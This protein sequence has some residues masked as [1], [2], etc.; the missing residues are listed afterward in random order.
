VGIAM[1]S[2][3]MERIDYNEPFVAEGAVEHYLN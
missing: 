2:K 3:D 1:L